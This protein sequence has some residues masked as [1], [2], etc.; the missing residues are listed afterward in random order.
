MFTGIIED[1]G[2]VVKWSS[3][4][5][6]IITTLDEIRKGD[7]VSLNGICL[8][9][10]RLSK[11]HE[12]FTMDFDYSPETKTRTNIG[13]LKPG[14][15]VNI[16]RSLKVGNRFGG[17]IMT[18]HIEATARLLTKER[19]EDSWLYEFS[20]EK[21]IQKYVVEKGSVGV[22]GISL[23]VVDAGANSFSVAVIPYT[24][25]N[26]NLGSRHPGER[27]N[28]EPDILAK[29]VEHLLGNADTKILTGEVLKKYGFLH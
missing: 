24:L 7:S 23:T 21:R 5:M 8:T 15:L 16:E 9:V 26:T 4:A 25:S 11:A 19:Q 12:G 1:V 14:S 29:Y 28:I 27:V 10:T 13:D 6:S 17:H 2:T 18:G 3:S 20:M 22:D